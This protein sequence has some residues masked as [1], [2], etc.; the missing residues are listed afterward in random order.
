MYVIMPFVELKKTDKKPIY[1]MSKH[2]VI[3]PSNKKNQKTIKE[4]N[5][6]LMKHKLFTPFDF[7][8]H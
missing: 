1:Q 2:E 5:K 7:P 3:K 8:N 6:I 4:V